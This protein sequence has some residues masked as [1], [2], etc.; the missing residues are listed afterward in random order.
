M[1]IQSIDHIE[2]FAENAE[3]AA[4]GLRDLFGFTL[5]GRGG[6]RTGLQGCESVLLRQHDITLLVTSATSAG[7]RAAEYVERHGD[8]VG[9]IGLRVDDAQAAFAQ[10]VER[11]AAPVAPPEILGPP[12]ARTVF[13][14]VSGFGDVEHRFVSR[15]RPGGPFAP[16]IEE[17]AR[18]RPA[19]G[20]FT[21]ID[22]L[23]VCVPAGT[24]KETVHTYE[25]VFGLHQIY[26]E[27]IVVGSQ[28]MDSTV[29]QSDSGRLTLTLIEPDITRAPGQIDRFIATHDGA[30]VQHI[31]FLTGDI[32]TAVPR[33]AER[34]VRFLTTPSGYYDRLGP[35]LGPIG[36]P[37]EELRG[38]GVLADRD[39][40]GV[41]LQIFTESQHRRGTLFYELIDRR[42]AHTFGSNNIKALYE[43]VDR[44]QTSKPAGH[45]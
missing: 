24:L 37:V 21:A 45:A 33:S 39:H 36:V 22:H 38:L 16:L 9:V 12:G 44:R 30:G 13:A 32:L 8:G 6:A 31:A 14:S 11:G 19:P 23:A 26:E 15:E 27:Q 5:A 40:T 43:A 29:V 42:G 34:G 41:M 35:R 25:N 3:E 4:L 17:T 18:T 10:A 20:L 7:H 1:E 2:F 28:A